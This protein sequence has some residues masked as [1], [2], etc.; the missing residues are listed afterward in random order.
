MTLP[1]AIVRDIGGE[2]WTYA[3]IRAGA[4][5][6]VVVRNDAGTEIVPSSA[7]TIDPVT[8]T[9]NGAIARG[10]S[11]ITLTSAADIVSGREYRI[12]PADPTAATVPHESVTVVSVAA[13]VVTLAR[14]TRYPHAT[15]VAFAGTRLSRDVTA[16]QAAS[17]FWDG[18]ARWSWDAMP[19]WLPRFDTAV[20]CVRHRIVNLCTLEAWAAHD[21][22]VHQ[23]LASVLDPETHLATAF[24][25]VLLALG[26]KMR[27]QTLRGSDSLVRATAMRASFDVRMHNGAEPEVLEAAEKRYRDALGEIQA[28][29]ADTDQDG[30][31]EAHE[32]V[33]SVWD[34]R[35]RRA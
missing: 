17:L 11:A 13:A 29:G 10:V 20:E 33:V 8:T 35:L 15:G 34:G 4:N 12:G 1:Q 21:P 25:S 27:A 31:V 2:V 26:G 14:P 18:Y 22:W 32:R 3:P 28:W 24:Q 7:A 5:P 19:S 6:V 30:V 16:A 9:L 23:F